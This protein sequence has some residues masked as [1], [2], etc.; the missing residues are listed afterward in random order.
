MIP[1]FPKAVATT[2]ER[3]DLSLEN[4][5]SERGQ[6]EQRDAALGFTESRQ[7]MGSRNTTQGALSIYCGRALENFVEDSEFGYLWATF[8]CA[9]GE[10]VHAT[11][12]LDRAERLACGHTDP[13]SCVLCRSEWAARS[14]PPHPAKLAE[15]LPR[16]RS[17]ERWS[18]V[19]GALQFAEVLEEDGPRLVPASY[20]TTGF[21]PTLEH[22]VRTHGKIPTSSF[23]LCSLF[24]D[25]RGLLQ[26]AYLNFPRAREWEVAAAHYCEGFAA[27]AI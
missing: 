20:V 26:E 7:T 14:R 9:H 16:L 12:M 19:R 1:P 21:H 8:T 6:L 11:C 4:N 5:R 27:Y 23:L 24:S 13:Q 10:F 25:A 2:P 18:A 3:T 17:G 15:D 22:M